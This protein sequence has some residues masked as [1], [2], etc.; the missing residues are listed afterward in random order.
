MMQQHE[1]GPEAMDRVIAGGAF[2]HLVETVRAC[3]DEGLFVGD[4][5]ALGLSLWAATHGVAALLVAKPS[6]PWPPVEEF[7]DATVRMAG[8]GLVAAS[9]PDPL[10]V[11]GLLEP[12]G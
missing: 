3:V 10:G 12:P 6:F 9:R 8:L 5:V 2:A 7:V 1:P 4:P 11:A